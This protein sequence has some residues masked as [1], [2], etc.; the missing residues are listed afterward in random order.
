MSARHDR[1]ASVSIC[2]AAAPRV[3]VYTCIDGSAEVDVSSAR[4]LVRAVRSIPFTRMGFTVHN[5]SPRR[6]THTPQATPQLSL[7]AT[8]EPARRT[9]LGTLPFI[10]C[11]D[12]INIG[13]DAIARLLTTT[14]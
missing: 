2:T 12:V 5:L 6:R 13:D 8:D 4:D 7:L 3:D 10:R 11:D 14:Q 1:D 9:L